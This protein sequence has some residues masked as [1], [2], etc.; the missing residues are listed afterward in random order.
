MG[1]KVM[2]NEHNRT[3]NKAV[4]DKISFITYIVP[5]F[6]D[7]YKM[8]VQDAYFYLKKH[9][10]WDFLNE[11]WWALHTDSPFWAVRSLYNVCYRNGGAR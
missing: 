2:V 3:I 1:E 7:A 6:A 5:A 11:H 10:A 9:G 8:N 4:S